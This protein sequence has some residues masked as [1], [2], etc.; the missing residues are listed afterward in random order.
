MES[1]IL[2]KYSAS[3]GSGKTHKLTSIYLSKLFGSRNAFKR[4][5]AVTFTNKAASEMK[6]KILGELY[7]L[8]KGEET[9]I[10]IS[11]SEETG[12][13]PE[14]L[15][16]EAK[17]ILEIILHDYSGFFVGTIDSFFQKVL[18][19][20]TRE[21]GLQNGYTLEIDHSLILSHAV[22]DMLADIGNDFPL[23]KWITEYARIRIENGK[24]WNLKNDILKLAEEI[25]K[26][27]FKL[28]TEQERE[29]LKDREYLLNYVSELKI[30]R[31]DFAKELIGYADRCT[32]ML[33]KHNVAD[34]MFLRGNNGGVP[35]FIKAMREGPK[36][37]YKPLNATINGLLE[38]DPVWTNKSGQTPELKSAMKDG[39]GEL[40]IEAVTYYKNNWLN[41]NTSGFIL[42]NIYTLG[43]LADILEH[44]HIITSAENRFLLS[45]AGELLYLIIANDQTP[46]IYEK[47]GNV[48]NHFMIDEF[49]DTSYIQWN[50]FRPLIENSMAEGHDNLV[51]GDIKQ[52]IYRW[53]NSDWKIFGSLLHDQI[54]KERLKTEHL[55]TNWRSRKNIISF[56]NTLFSILPALIEN[57][58]GGDS[59][60]RL[61]DLFSD[62]VQKY[63]G[64]K[65]DGYVKIE[66]IETKDDKSFP[67]TV[68]EKL[69]SLI[70]EL[71]D[72]G[73]SGSDIGILVRK[74][75]EGTEVLNYILDYHSHLS[76]EKR[77]K[78]NYNI[79]SNESLLLVNSP[80]VNFIIS[81]FTGLYDPEDNLSKALM[82][83]N[84][85]LAT[86][87][88]PAEFLTVT[89]D[90][91]DKD[92]ETYFPPGYSGFIAGVK[93]MTLFEAV[94]NIILF[95]GLG[96][97]PENTAYLNTFQDCVLE[98]SG[99]MSADIPSFLE[100]WENTGV[101]KSII[102]SDQHDSMRVMT[103]HK[104]KGL[105]FRVVILPFISWNLGHSKNPT[106]WLSPKTVPFNKLGLVP[107]KYKNDL[108]Y[109]HFAS[110]YVK[111]TF[112][113][114]VDSLNMLYVAFTRAID[115]LYGFCPVKSKSTSL[116]GWI[117]KA[118]QDETNTGSV[119][120]SLVL[121]QFLNPEGNLLKIGEIPE[122]ISDT[123]SKSENRIMGK[124]Y[125]VSHGIN[126]LF[127][128]FHG[129][130]WMMKLAE[131]QKNKLNYGRIMHEVF[132]AV[133]TP[134]D[135]TGAVNKLVLEGKIPESER[136]EIE[137]KVRISIS[138]PAVADWFKPGLNVL[139]EAE[140]LTSAGAAKR[141]DRVILMNDRV[142]LIDFKF[143]AEKEEYLTQ[144]NNYRHLLLEMGY[145]NVD[146]FLWFVDNNKVITVI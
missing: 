118:L 121:K 30:L 8:A 146:A 141:P 14:K 35:S 101:R 20:F 59:E 31:S 24:S 133:I 49:Q 67:E 82:V 73:Y 87:K 79:V 21:I 54:S 39:F 131:G 66:Y 13:S 71:Q 46:F 117:Y 77:K 9:S 42:E 97:Y 136:I 3:A 28:L 144:V 55:E 48:F 1:G 103:I 34:N 60:S 47:V 98:F 4:I 70:E 65:E 16:A 130:S 122:R 90:D 15:K 100:W 125:F 95:F 110:D 17:E 62:S 58:S 83:R 6:R 68:L 108:Q 5:L 107:V 44:I 52:S 145:S 43:I 126:H 74:N 96:N 72:N 124:E 127:L 104:S 132:E 50:N 2:T 84:W 75:T 37:V 135:I 29:K 25:F 93:R 116:P 33:D 22:D 113:A 12:K 86:C 76:D 11:L 111:E 92:C 41:A 138:D 129:E 89:G 115:C 112:S 85:L 137:E 23:R 38:S 109:S 26:E 123:V 106:F 142:I 40:C 78:Y 99:S 57:S 120:P 27:K 63:P 143:G 119:K 91:C 36:T 81:L 102:L 53:R 56:N 45:D 80:A 139:T 51:V 7:S 88:D 105:E 69:P 64:K 140:I 10:S 61:S 18:K 114:N 128:K 134:G 32:Q 19:A 94:E